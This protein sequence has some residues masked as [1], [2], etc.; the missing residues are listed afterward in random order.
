MTGTLWKPVSQSLLFFLPAVA[1]MLR[2]V[3]TFD[4]NNN[5]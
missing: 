2:R 4:L 5:S 3:F 1:F